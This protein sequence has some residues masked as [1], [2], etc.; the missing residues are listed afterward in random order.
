MQ[1]IYISSQEADPDDAIADFT[2]DGRYF[3]TFKQF[4]ALL[5]LIRQESLWL[6]F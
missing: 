3:Y 1:K 5:I 6:R 4:N 2:H